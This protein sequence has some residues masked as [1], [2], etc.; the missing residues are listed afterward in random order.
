MI[1]VCHLGKY[2][3]PAPGGIET[4]VR[5]LAR[6]QADL[7][8]QV[9]VFCVNHRPGPTSDEADGPVAVRRFGRR[10][11]LDK[12]DVCPGLSAGPDAGRSRRAAPARTQPDDD[13]G[14][15]G[16]AAAA[17]D[18]RDVPERRYPP[19]HPRWMFRPLERLA[20]RRVPAVLQTSPL[21]AG[22]SRFLRPYRDRLDVLPNGIDLA[23]YL[24]PAPRIGRRPSGSEP[25]TKGPSGSVAAGWSTTRA[26][27]SPCGP[28]GASRAR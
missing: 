3:P 21:Y 26:S 11:R 4:N 9:Q 10:A 20:Y 19:A 16:G 17:A 24:D 12:L 15:P 6:A 25:R 7:G 28:C 8:A 22:G 1:K 5:I 27:R 13:P 18:R 2:Y 23:P 14:D